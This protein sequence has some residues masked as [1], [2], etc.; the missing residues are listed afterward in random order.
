MAS[1]AG[2]HEGGTDPNAG[3]HSTVD[4]F[5]SD[6]THLTTIHVPH[7]VNTDGWGT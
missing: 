1:Q 2:A 5:K 4:V 7:D 3:L 6:G